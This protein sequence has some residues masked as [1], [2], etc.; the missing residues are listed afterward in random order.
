MRLLQMRLCVREMTSSGGITA[1]NGAL[2]EVALQN[3][4]PRESV[5][6]KYAHVGSV[7]SVY[8]KSES[9]L[10]GEILCLTSEQV[11]FQMLGMKVCFCA[12]RTGKFSLGIFLGNQCTFCRTRTW[13]DWLS[14]WSTR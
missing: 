5:S 6:T 3:I 10:V 2:L 4:A 14:P 13:T 9:L 12:V 11:A 8:M 1:A 7:T